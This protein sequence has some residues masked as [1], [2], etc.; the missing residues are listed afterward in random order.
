LG[1]A[2]IVFGGLIIF[3]WTGIVRPSVMWA[4]ALIIVGVILYRGELPQIGTSKAAP[5]TDDAVYGRD[6]ASAA[7]TVEAEPVPAVALSATTAE[8][9]A[10]SGLSTLPPEPA[11][12]APPALPPAPPRP[13]SMLGR[14]T[15]AVG[16]IA[17]GL[18]ALLD[19][20]NVIN[21][22]FRHYLAVAVGVVG[23]GLL[24]GT[25][26]GRSWGLIALGLLLMPALL[27]ATLVQ[28]PL[29]GSFGDRTY[30][31]ET[32]AAIPDDYEL[33]AGS[34]KIDLRDVDLTD[35]PV[36]VTATVGFGELVVTVPAA[37]ATTVEAKAGF[38]EVVIDGTTDGGIN[39]KRT[40]EWPGVGS[41]VV[42]VEV[43]F[44][45][46]RIIRVE[47]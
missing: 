19:T 39:V 24:V 6:T 26:W 22:D 7:A 32:V 8:I 40:S 47:T 34:L 43:G 10:E 37:A 35:G 33:A 38:G 28:V 18:M 29:R 30:R 15:I 16:L 1:I 31:P 2:L 46:A 20:A 44:G 17:M 36:V 11:Q 21:P 45:S 3:S 12:P 5:A 42:D 13:K 27:A 41:I 9:S 4:G 14:M 23:I 25:L